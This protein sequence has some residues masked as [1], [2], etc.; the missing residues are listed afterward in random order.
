MTKLTRNVS[1][2]ESAAFWRH[3]DRV[4]AAMRDAP[5][6]KM[7]GIVLDPQHYETYPPEPELDQREAPQRK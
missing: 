3:V 6:W 4:A 5:A 1:D 7:A 2:P